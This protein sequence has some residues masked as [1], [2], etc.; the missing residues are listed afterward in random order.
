MIHVG[1]YHIQRWTQYKELVLLYSPPIIFYSRD[2]HPLRKPPYGL[3][4]IFYHEFDTY[5][6]QDYANGAILFKTKIPLSDQGPRE[7][8]ITHEAI[9]HFIHAEVGKLKISPIHEF[10]SL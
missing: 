4:L 6:F 7:V 2:P 3:K 9:E 1:I 5:I 10:W 8:P